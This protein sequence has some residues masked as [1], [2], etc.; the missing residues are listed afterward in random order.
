MAELTECLPRKPQVG[1]P[2]PHKIDL[3]DEVH[4]SNPSNLEVEKQK[5][6]P[7]LHNKFKFK[8]ILDYV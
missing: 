8:S 2:T 7:W 4:A 6:H 1:S 5:G 3:G